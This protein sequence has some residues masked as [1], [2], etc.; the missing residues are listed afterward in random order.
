MSD[1]KKKAPAEVPCTGRLKLQGM[2]KAVPCE[3]EEGHL[4]DH[5]SVSSGLV[6]SKT[7]TSWLVCRDPR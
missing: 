3:W 2:T 1:D 7:G 5:R 4:G 6:W